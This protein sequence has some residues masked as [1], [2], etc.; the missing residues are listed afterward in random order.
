MEERIKVGSFPYALGRAQGLQPMRTSPPLELLDPQVRD[1]FLQCF[2]EG[3]S[4]PSVRPAA[5]RWQEALLAAEAALVACVDNAQHCYGRHLPACPWCERRKM[6]RGI[7]SFPSEAEVKRVRFHRTFSK[8]GRSV[9]HGQVDYETAI[10][11][12]TTAIARMQRERAQERL[13]LSVLLVLIFIG[14]I[15]LIRQVVLGEWRP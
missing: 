8:P 13:V 4:H 11:I 2:V 7:D 6:L 5:Q 3:H 1:L 14:L 15:A 10:A 12:A 9:W